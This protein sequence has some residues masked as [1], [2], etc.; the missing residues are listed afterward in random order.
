MERDVKMNISE[1]VKSAVN[2]IQQHTEL[3]PTVGVVLGSGLGEFANQLDNRVSIP[4]SE[5]PD[6]PHATVTG[7]S[8][9]FV[10]GI[11]EGTPVI[12]LNGRI[13]FY[14]GYTLQQVTLPTRV[15]AAFGVKT[16]IL[17]NAAG[18][19][20][21]SFR[22][23][24]LMLLEDHINISGFNPLIGP[25]MD[26]FG[27]RFPDM[28]EVYD[29]SLREK[30][31]TQYGDSDPDLRTGVYI[32]YSGPSYETPT[33]IRF[34]RMAG[35]DA[36]GMSTVPEAIVAR[37]SGMRVVGIS[38]ITNMAAGILKQKLNHAEVVDVAAKTRTR[39]LK[40]LSG[41]IKLANES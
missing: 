39:F 8:G 6:F 30:L 40:L 18:G 36:V 1:I 12:A 22:P 3:R 2:I 16:L 21:T 27:P 38:C 24:T 10:V 33:E 14:E 26:E 11:H 20:N 23:G 35:A 25:N 17:T 4:F 34:F 41:A 37:H 15:M 32:M 19:I 7:H 31:L 28:S 5:I 13:H 9:E 29:S